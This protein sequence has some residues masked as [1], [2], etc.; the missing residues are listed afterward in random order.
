MTGR[1]DKGRGGAGARKGSK[2][3]RWQGLLI[4]AVLVALAA[5]LWLLFVDRYAER[6]IESAGTSVVGAKVELD[7]ADVSLSPLGLT[8]VGLKV[9]DPDAPMTNAFE[10]GRIAFRMD[11]PNALRRKIIIE[12]M[13]VEDVRLNTP[14]KT[15][16]AVASTGKTPLEQLA[17]L[18]SFV[19][20][21]VKEAF[22]KEKADLRSLKLVAGAAAD[23]ETAR[24]RW[25]TKLK[26]LEAA[27]DVEKYQK[28]Y[29][30]LKAKTGKVTVGN[31]L[32][33]SADLLA[34]QKEVRADIQTVSEAK[35]LFAADFSALQKVAA[36]APAAVREDAR[37]IIDKYSLT[38]AGLSN[39]SRLLFGPK[40]AANVRSALQWN[41]R[42]T[43]FIE[44]VKEKVNGR[45]VVKPVRASGRNVRFPEDRPLPDFLARLAKV[46]ISLPQGSFAGRI[47]NMTSDPDILGQPLKFAFSG[48]KLKG[49]RSVSLEGTFDRVDPAARRD[50]LNLRLRGYEARGV[51]LV[52][53]KS[54]PVDL[55]EGLADLDISASLEK[56]AFAARITAG[57]RSARLVIGQG[58]ERQGLAG[59][60]DGAIRSA[61]AG[62]TSLS[63][64]AEITGT[65]E[66]FDLKVRSDLD[67]VLK[68][69]VGGLVRDQLAGF[70]GDIQKA[71]AGEVD[72][73][74]AK[75][76]AGL[77]GLEAV[78]LDLDALN[79]KLA[80]LL[81]K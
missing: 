50:V 26:D 45:D 70:E 7:K 79:K 43:P 72:G 46:S 11:G 74:L 34:L 40:I 25:A 42:L 47:E 33:G 19:I 13:S 51:K 9:T 41:E 3:V 77:K 30:E 63:L 4:F 81:K 73:P 49:L 8:L 21:N 52:A 44:R 66:D 37:R 36:D 62:V 64:T 27:A 38:P 61:L 80:E 2:V 18:P 22:E 28:R 1:A 68:S 58:E 14:R 17:E 48:E 6:A 24:A 65:P 53:S 10:A 35:K 75:L 20:P 15:S 16:G 32:G 67:E 56:G 55:A 31:L 69:A 71:I 12:E 59:R 39:I 5:G 57:V 29:A 60:V 78:G 76:G 23:A 54:L